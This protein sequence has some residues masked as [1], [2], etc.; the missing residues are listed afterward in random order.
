MD[1]VKVIYGSSNGNTREA[2]MLIANELG[3][4][5]INVAGANAGDFDA[6]L[7][8]LGTSTWGIGELQ[9]DWI[10]GLALLD[11]VDWSGKKVALFGLGDQDG[12]GDSYLD[13][14]RELYDRLQANHATVIGHW[15]TE[16]YCHHSSRAEMNGEFVGLALDADNQPNLTEARIKE[17]CRQLNG[18][19]FQ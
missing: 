3:G 15:S 1:K 8:V 14:L 9:D 10:A 7:V 2:A 18:N 6:E 5:A 16:G 19:V 17:W 11:T 4:S 13:G 12:F